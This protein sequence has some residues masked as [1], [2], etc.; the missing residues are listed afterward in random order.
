MADQNGTQLERWFY[1]LT[2]NTL[3]D[4]VLDIP[5]A[6]IGVN[7]IAGIIWAFVYA[8]VVEPRLSGPGWR[9]GMLFA[10]APWLLSLVVFFPIV[11]AGFFGADLDAGPLPAFGNLA[12]HLVYG[13]ALGSMYAVPEVTPTTD[14]VDD[15]RTARLEND[16][17]AAGLL[18]GL[19]VGIAGGG[20]LGMFVNSDTFTD[21]GLLLVGGALGSAI[22]GWLG[23]FAGLGVGGSRE[24]L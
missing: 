24:A 16:G 8:I 14:Q 9:K 21:S 3:T 20:L 4:G 10:L 7:L 19:L 5:V 23:A 15:A 11:G 17:I 12:L 22:G 13:A 2:E 6:A 1:G 18:V